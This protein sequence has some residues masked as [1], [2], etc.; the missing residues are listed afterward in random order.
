MRRVIYQH[1]YDYWLAKYPALQTK[2][3]FRR[4]F[5][6]LA[7]G[8]DKGGKIVL[9]RHTVA[10]IEG[11]EVTKDYVAQRFLDA[12]R[13]AFPRF[14]YSGYS[15]SDKKCRIALNDGFD[16]DDY[17]RITEERVRELDAPRINF[18]TGQRL[19]A[20]GR[21]ALREEDKRSI[22][23]AQ[24]DDARFIQAYINN[25][26]PRGFTLL[27]A[28]MPR[29][30]AVASSLH[31][32]KPKYMH[33]LRNYQLDLLNEIEEQPQPFIQPSWAGKTLR[34]MPKNRGISLLE[35]SVRRALTPTWTELDLRAAQ[36]AICAKLW[37]V[38][39]VQAFL[40]DQ[41][42]SIWRE[43]AE[44]LGIDPITSKKALKNEGV[45]P[46]F[47]GMPVANVAAGVTRE[48][49]RIG[50]VLQGV[51]G[52][53]YGKRFLTHPLITDMI[54]GRDQMLARIVDAGGA[55]NY[56]GE[57][58][59]YQPELENENSVLAQLSQAVEMRLIVPV[60]QV[61]EESEGE[62]TVMLYQF[63][64]V[65]ITTRRS[66]QRPYWI[67]K[68]KSAVRDQARAMEIETYLEVAE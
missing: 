5:L 58:L 68:A 62:F 59:P 53:S 42:R 45:Y 48:L 66:N 43:L 60:F 2:I 15:Y 1:N 19:D 12:Y 31:A 65:S 54:A 10:E 61:A 51:P 47:Y 40:R 57:W 30:R 64:G 25:L 35:K 22:P 63:D 38:E 36:F 27:L 20:K 46:L 23:P 29:A 50:Y 6:K 26:P 9:S 44:Y 37:G 14:R 21:M 11:A 7:F 18:L 34:L 49:A 28:N 24:V 8:R 3:P 13:E 17:K 39:S 4:M 32:R 56:Y 67:D 33:I 16:A 52:M 55:F 41:T